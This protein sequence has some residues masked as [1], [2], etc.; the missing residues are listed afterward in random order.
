MKIIISELHL[1]NFRSCCRTFGADGHI[2]AA[3]ASMSPSPPPLSPPP[4]TARESMAMPCIARGGASA[5]TA[6]AS[7]SAVTATTTRRQSENKNETTTIYRQF[8]ACDGG[9]SGIDH[10]RSASSA[11]ADIRVETVCRGAQYGRVAADAAPDAIVD[12]VSFSVVVVDC[13]LRFCVAVARVL[14]QMYVGTY[15]KVCRG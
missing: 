12:A 4:P 9:G 3:V 7:A 2:K 15:V 1:L 14:R 6:S 13:R 11:A 5:A 8:S 10:N